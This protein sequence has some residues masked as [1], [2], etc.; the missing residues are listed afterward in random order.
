[1]EN[2]DYTIN[3]IVPFQVGDTLVRGRVVQLGSA[4]HQI[5]SAHD[6]DENSS[7]LVGEVA[8]LAA[9]MGAALKFDGKLIF[10]IQGDGPV[11]LIAAD[12]ATDGSLRAMA[13]VGEVAGKKGLTDLVGHGHI[14]ITI[15]Q[16]PDMERY[17]GVTA[18]EGETLEK[19]AVA[20]FI[21]SEQ[22]P[23]VIKLAVGR[24]SRP[25][26]DDEWRAGGIMAQFIPAEGGERARGEDMA[27]SDDDQ[28]LWTRTAAFV[29]STQT[30][31]LLDPSISPETLLYRLFHEDGVRVFDRSTVN[32]NCACN[33]Q[34]IEAV[35]SKYQQSDLAEMIEDGFIRVSCEFCRSRYLFDR[36]GAF[37]KN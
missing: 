5:L 25:G 7:A 22:I 2:V 29:E 8:V 3:Q 21:Q 36:T 28:E 35:L 31:E 4:I 37:V 9:L 24:V 11:S 33:E 32:A 15:D 14:A 12:Y 16:G 27:T 23:T 34:K 1:M 20:Y 18:I 10:Q 30:D 17:R 13:T 6:F 19:A 26:S